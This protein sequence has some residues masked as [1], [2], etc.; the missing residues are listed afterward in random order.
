MSSVQSLGS[1]RFKQSSSKLLQRRLC[2]LKILNRSTLP[3]LSLIV[4]ASAVGC[5]KEKPADTASGGEPKPAGQKLKIAVIPKG[6]AAFFWQAV[7]S[8][9]QQAGKDS[10]VD[11]IWQGPDKE[12]SITD[13]INLV[14]SQV[15][16]KV[17][18]IVIAASDATALVKPVKDAMAAHIPVVTV[19]SGLTEKD[20]S[21]AL[22]ATDNVE[23]GRRAAD[24][25]AKEIGEKGDVGLLIFQ[26]GSASSDDRENGFLEGIKKY[27][28]IK[29][30]STLESNDPQKAIDTTTN[31]LT[32]NPTIVG[33][34]A[35]NE[36]NGV[37]AA[38]VI[39]QKKL[40][41]K[42]KLIAYD[43]SPEEL[44]DLEDGIIQATIVQDPYQMGYKGV[45]TCIKA[46]KK[47]P[48]AEKFVNSGMTV[49][50]AA[51]LHTP[52]VQKLVNPEASK[53]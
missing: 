29:L 2:A 27:P 9:A 21:V 3:I 43:S 49:V 20:A 26:K 10:G 13:Q 16:N 53:K 40:I 6:T 33:I 32:A 17:D 38:N 39:K 31:M 35:A 45:M 34:F 47:E 42:I 19:D 23:G 44:K 22:I 1:Y 18:G 52:E 48:I 15:T 14:Q 11:I 41:G 25:L 24:T 5:A 4:I 37:G 12:G 8:G 51:N 7:D 46:I 30:V 28:N 36:L 50:T